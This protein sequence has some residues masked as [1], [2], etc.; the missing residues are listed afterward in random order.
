MKTWVS[1]LIIPKIDA[2]ILKDETPYVRTSQQEIT[3]LN[4]V[5]YKNLR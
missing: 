2:S 3:I 5:F 1:L 4:I